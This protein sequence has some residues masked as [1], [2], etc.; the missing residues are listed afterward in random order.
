MKNQM[1]A[2]KA[3]AGIGKN[4]RSWERRSVTVLP[5]SFAGSRTVVDQFDS[6]IVSFQVGDPFILML[7]AIEFDRCAT[8][9]IKNHQDSARGLIARTDFA[10]L[11]GIALDPC[12]LPKA[13]PGKWFTAHFSPSPLKLG[14]AVARSR[15]VRESWFTLARHE[16]PTPRYNT[17]PISISATIHRGQPSNNFR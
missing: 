6:D 9:R 11:V 17:R 3:A 16:Q 8:I 14:G 13:N 7:G 5:L 12:K 1:L 15:I 10:G 4:H 2:H